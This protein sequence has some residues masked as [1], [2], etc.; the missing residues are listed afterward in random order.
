MP[1]SRDII[2]AMLIDRH[3]IRVGLREVEIWP[4]TIQAWLAQGY[5]T[6]EV[7]AEDGSV[8]AQPVDWVAHFGFDLF[9]AGPAFLIDSQPLRGYSEVI[10]ETDE[11]IITRN[12][13]GAAVK[14]W[15][16][17]A[18]A[19]E[20]IEHRM[21]SRAIWERD[22]RPHLLQLDRA[23]VNIAGARQGLAQHRS[24]G[25]Y[26]YYQ[27]GLLFQLASGFMG[28]V[29]FWQALVLDPDWIL[30]IN[31]VYTDFYL[32]HWKLLLDEAGVPDGVRL[33]DDFAYRGGLFASPKTMHKLYLPF[34]REIVDFLHGYSLP[35]ELHVCGDARAA[36][37][38]LLE[39]GFD[40][41]NPLERK[42]GMDPLA[43][44][45]QYGDR[46]AF[47]GGMD[48][49]VLETGDLDTI[50]R[51]VIRLV[52]GMTARGAR[53]V[54]GSDHSVP[55]TVDYRSYRYACEVCREHGEYAG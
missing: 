33:I 55:P 8:K 50:R 45:E 21:T 22:Y 2:R 15:K 20:H 44:A 48:V 1:S 6:G 32:A 47:I 10:A 37:P 17:R 49:R 40:I 23:R 5:P 12:G 14:A 39:A 3:P 27:A 24:Q 29:D 9:R 13:A 26:A 25:L 11:W 52:T 41:I 54:W 31:R 53:F 28:D 35:V 18:G 46:L 34:Y 36:I 42:A 4:E 30:D 38:L 43:L 51:E 7:A 16:Q 19:R